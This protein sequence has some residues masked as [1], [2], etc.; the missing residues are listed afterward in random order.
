M[1]NGE[2]LGPFGN[3]VLLEEDGGT[4]GRRVQLHATL[5]KD[6]RDSSARNMV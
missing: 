1:G 4:G 6:L 5:L 2:I 3:P